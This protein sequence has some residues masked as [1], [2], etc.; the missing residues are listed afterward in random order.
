M[1]AGFITARRAQPGGTMRHLSPNTKEWLAAFDKLD[2]QQAA[3][4]KKII[5]AAG[6]EVVCSLCGDRHASDY[7]VAD[8]WFDEET[9]VT[10]RLCED[11]MSI[12]AT[13]DGERLVPLSHVA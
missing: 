9:P 12:R 2:P 6:S 3:A 5:R 7:E 11:C 4:T 10:L 13:N 1:G 8:K